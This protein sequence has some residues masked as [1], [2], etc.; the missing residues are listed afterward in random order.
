MRGDEGQWGAMGGIEGLWGAVRGCPRPEQHSPD[1]CRQGP[2]SGTAPSSHSSPCCDHLIWVSKQC[3]Q[4]Q[5][6]NHPSQTPLPP[7]SG[8]STERSALAAEMQKENTPGAVGDP[9]RGSVGISQLGRYHRMRH[10]PPTTPG[11]AAPSCHTC[12]AHGSSQP[13]EG[14]LHAA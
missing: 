12:G 2:T 4:A 5:N 14:A 7:F 6:G 13:W 8:A 9:T 3:M 10:H 1:C 11:T